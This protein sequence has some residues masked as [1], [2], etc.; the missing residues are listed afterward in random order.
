MHGT[1]V[2]VGHAEAEFHDVELTH[3]LSIHGRAITEVTLAIVQANV[4]NRHG[5]NATGRGATILS[6]PWAW[7]HSGATIHDRDRALRALTERIC[8]EA[9]TGCARDPIAHW[10]ALA[11]SLDYLAADPRVTRTVTEPLPHLACAL[12]L[13]AVDNAIHDA[14]ARAAGKPAHAMYTADHLAHDLADLLGAE[15]TGRY[16]ADYLPAPRG[17]LAVQHVVGAT[18]PLDQA[19]TRNGSRP[20]AA[21]M[22]ADRPR[23]LKIKL[24][25]S[26]LAEDADRIVAVHAVTQRQPPFTDVTLAVDPNEAYASPIRVLDLLDAVSSRSPSARRAITYVE[27]PIARDQGTDHEALRRV[28]AQVPILLDEGL[29]RLSDL[30]GLSTSGWSGA[31]IKAGKGQTMSVLV[32]SYVHAHGMYVTL[33]DLTAVDLALS[34]SAR[35]ASTLNLSAPHFEYNSRQYA[36]GANHQLQRSRPDLVTVTDGKVRIAPPVEPGLY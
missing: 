29:A 13:G 15:F 35:L 18:D 23:H 26:D 2:S 1:E 30:R 19:D 25:G 7:P 16:P 33:Q 34:H 28:A 31:V 8:R 9:V 20:L 32:H 3:P 6:I 14:W 11:G 10:R 21:W 17:A 22:S 12:A 27:Q 4:T 5:A 24:L 36:P